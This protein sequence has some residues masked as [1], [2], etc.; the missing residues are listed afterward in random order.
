MKKRILIIISRLHI[1]GAEKV[2][3]DIALHADRDA[4]Q[5]DYLLFS[6]EIG[7]YEKQLEAVGC[8][9]IRIPEPSC[10]YGNHIRMLRRIIQDNRYDIVHAHTMF[11]C[12]WAMWVAKQ[13]G[14]PVRIAHS[15]SALANGNG[16]V[17]SV[18]EKLMRHM[19]LRCA[20]D[21][22]GC[23]EKAGKRLFSE[24]SWADHGQLIH[25][26]IDVAGFAYAP[27]KR[28]A[29]RQQ[30]SLGD[31]FVLG[32]VG[33]LAEVKNQK[34]LLDLMPD[35]LKHEPD[36][37][38]LLLGE[39][40][41]R[42]MLEGKIQTLGLQK[43]VIM[44]GNVNNVPDYLCAMDV[45]AFPSLYEGMPLSILEV[46]ANGLPCVIS[47]RVPADVFLTDLIHPLSLDNPE[48]WIEKICSVKRE[49]PEVY[50]TQMRENGFDVTTAVE[51][52]Y[53][54]YDR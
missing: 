38:L 47:D 29:I 3:Q 5:F 34:F 25:N 37:V 12:G 16:F 22:V 54:I 2:A 41:D 19:I 42:A 4:Y 51:K 26:G 50:S 23:S 17:K 48:A 14:V 7:G 24:K 53:K 27:K 30:L 1:G 32:H 49:N 43:H 44:T 21:L 35:I 11:N 52:F 13:C 36:A 15:H 6:D 46:Q 31:R 33:H 39:G 8:R 9:M 20:T 10:G 28:N 18:Y 40:E 45:F